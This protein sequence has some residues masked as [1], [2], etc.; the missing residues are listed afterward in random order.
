M[1]GTANSDLGLFVTDETSGMAWF[2][3]RSTEQPR[4]YFFIGLLIGIAVLNG[5][6]LPV[7]FPSTMYRTLLADFRERRCEELIREGWPDLHNNFAKLLQ[8][9]ESQGKLEDVL[10]R[11]YAFNIRTFDGRDVEIDMTRYSRLDGSWKEWRELLE[12]SATTVTA[13][14]PPLVGLGNR[15]QFVKDYSLWLV[16]ISVFDQVEACSEGFRALFSKRSL[17]ALTPQCLQI[18]TEGNGAIDVGELER[19]TQYENY[20]RDEPIIQGF[21]EIVRGYTPERIRALLKF[22]TASDRVPATG[23]GNLRFKIVRNGYA[24]SEVCGSSFEFVASKI[25]LMRSHLALADGE[26]VLRLSHVAAL[27]QQRDNAA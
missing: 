14:Q 18:I 27:L 6:T 3:P 25:R 19:V 26:Y 7:R 16:Y 21:W 5:F 10:C 22:V 23:V 9:D 17:R 11:P 1:I 20:D 12:P 15:H 2:D 24:D 13:V 8:M 4:Y